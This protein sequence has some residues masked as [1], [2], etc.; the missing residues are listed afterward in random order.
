MNTNVQGTITERHADQISEVFG[1]E[2][3]NK[4]R[5]AQPGTTFLDILFNTGGTR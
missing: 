1:D 4:V 3:A 2:L 5:N